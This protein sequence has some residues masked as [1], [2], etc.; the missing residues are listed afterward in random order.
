MKTIEA[1]AGLGIRD[2]VLDAAE[3]L[4]GR[5]GYAKTTMNDMADEAGVAKR[6]VYLHFTGKEAVA[7]A[8]IDRIVERLLAELRSLAAGSEGPA[9]RIRQMLLRRVLFRFDSVRGYHHRLD[10]LL[11]SV[12]PAYMARRQR[13]FEAEAQVFADVLAEGQLSRDFACPEVDATAEALLVATNALLPSGLSP[14]ELG[15]R[16]VVERRTLRVAGL[17]LDG[18]KVRSRR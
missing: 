9:E 1:P 11:D 7:L 3:R 18:L 10:E 14:R 6:T 16:R 12:R 5:Y 13:Y 4:L 8:T 17:L 15:Q 2:R